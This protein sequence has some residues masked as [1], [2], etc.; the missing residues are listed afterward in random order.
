[1]PIER[2]SGG[3]P[4]V[5]I[6][7]GAKNRVN[8]PS[9]SLHYSFIQSKPPRSGGCGFPTVRS[10]W[11]SLSAAAQTRFLSA[12]KCLMATDSVLDISKKQLRSVYDDFAY[13][14]FTLV[15]NVHGTASFLAWHRTLI[16]LFEYA[17]QDFCGYTGTLPYWDWTLDASNPSASPIFS[18]GAFGGNG[19]GTSQCI[20]NGA[21][22]QET[23]TINH[24]N[25][26]QCITRNFMDGSMNGELFSS[27][28]IQNLASTSTWGVFQQGI[29]VGPHSAVHN[30]VGGDFGYPP[31]AGN[32]PL[33]YV[34]H[35]QIDRVW[36]Q[37]QKSSR[38][39]GA[40]YGTNNAGNP[41]GNDAMASDWLSG[42]N[43][44]FGN[45][46]LFPPI[47]VSDAM[48]TDGGGWF[49]YIYGK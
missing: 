4:S 21:F 43:P 31:A 2:R 47:S 38:E 8:F 42:V 44:L 19:Q 11:R 13:A 48:W 33:F 34:H 26:P 49:C 16:L 36:A 22:N 40:Y 17:L 28:I 35:A 24:P 1:M 32:D 25:G 5:S 6:A 39:G 7:G 14:H 12:V 3:P 15:A 18:D 30:A 27:A 37:W 20:T 29:F 45:W 10:E 9:P 41:N 46:T 23:V